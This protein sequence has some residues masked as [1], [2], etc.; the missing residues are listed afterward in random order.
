ME[1]S[2]LYNQVTQFAWELYA[3]LLSLTLIDLYRTEMN[4]PITQLIYMNKGKLIKAPTNFPDI[5]EDKL[6]ADPCSNFPH[7]QILHIPN[8]CARTSPSLYDMASIGKG[9][10]ALLHQ[11][12]RP[13]RKYL[14]W[15]Q[16]C[17]SFSSA[18]KLIKGLHQLAPYI[19]QTSSFCHPFDLANATNQ[20]LCHLPS[21]S[22][23]HW[24][25][26]V[27]TFIHHHP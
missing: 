19:H 11:I 18:I 4:Y 17:S 21:L 6:T 25:L 26:S 8:V 22:D 16:Y 15:S 13:A 20:R 2:V 9:S 24:C 10:V 1:L 12:A 27:T 5:P 14:S 7:K 23:R 3:T